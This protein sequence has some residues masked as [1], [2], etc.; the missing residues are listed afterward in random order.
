[1]IAHPVP[2]P[3]IHEPNLWKFMRSDLGIKDVLRPRIPLDQ[4]S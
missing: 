2:L 3:E 1:V 4:Y